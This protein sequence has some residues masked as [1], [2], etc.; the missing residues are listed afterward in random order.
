MALRGRGRFTSKQ[1]KKSKDQKPSPD[2]ITRIVY[3]WRIVL[4]IDEIDRKDDGDPKEVTIFYH[5]TSECY[6]HNLDLKGKKKQR[7]LQMG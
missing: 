5:I 6:N 1:V 7:T 4:F 2:L 3:H